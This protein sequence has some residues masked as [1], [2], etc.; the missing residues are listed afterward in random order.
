MYPIT[1]RF[2]QQESFRLKGHTGIDFSMPNGTELRS[3]QDGIITRVVDFG[4]SNIGKGVFV[5]WEDGKTAIY[6]HLSKITVKVGQKVSTGDLLGLSGNSGNVVGKNG[7]YHLHFGL[8]EGSKFIDPSPFIDHIQNMNNIE[9]LHML[10]QQPSQIVPMVQKSL[11]FADLFNANTSIYTDLFNSLKLNV[12][13]MLN[14][15][16]YSVF[17]HYIQHFFKFFS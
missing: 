4:N 10:V 7:G 5:Q 15:V 9:K 17:I 14:S 11:T 2:L 6:G 16:D 12:I 1:S 8:K 3:I 13:H